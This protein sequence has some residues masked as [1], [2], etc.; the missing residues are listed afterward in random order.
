MNCPFCH[1]ALHPFQEADLQL[2]RCPAG[3]GIWFDGEELTAYRKA[4]PEL[5]M[6]TNDENKR[7]VALPGMPI[8]IAPVASWNNYK[9][10]AYMN[11]TCGSVLL[12]RE[13]F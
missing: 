11:Q 6:H 5:G 4:H 13:Y 1:I 7:F 3:H 2:D 12:A 9:A 10:D 8:K